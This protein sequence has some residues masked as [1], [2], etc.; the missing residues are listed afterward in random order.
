M[1]TES[2]E[3]LLL[4]VNVSPDISKSTLVTAT[5]VEEAVEDLFR[6]VVDEKA[7]RDERR[8]GSV[9]ELWHRFPKTTKT[10]MVDFGYFLITLEFIY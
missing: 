7:V 5:I 8:E 1:V 4:E 10:E 9:W 2:L 3:V 6:L